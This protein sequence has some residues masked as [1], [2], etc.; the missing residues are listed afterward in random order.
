MQL[1]FSHG[2]KGGVGKSTTAMALIEHCLQAGLQPFLIEGDTGIPDVAA[3]Y[4]GVI[5]GAQIPL[6]RPDLVDEAVGE[7]FE[8]LESSLDYLEGRPVI[9][10]LPAG[11]ASTVDRSAPLIHEVAQTAGWSITTIYLIGAGVE[12]ATAAEESLNSGLAGKSDKKIAVRNLAFG[13]PSRWPWTRGGHHERWEA[14]GG[15]VLDLEEL[16]ARVVNQITG[17]G[18]LGSMVTGEQGGLYLFDRSILQ[19]W[20]KSFSP[21]AE[22]AG[23]L[24][25]AHEVEV[26]EVASNE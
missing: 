18:P 16:A 25:P 4:R 22:A 5:E 14:A 9:V 7:L 21:I 2:E 10:N 8:L 19:R 3:R 13:D 12:S 17:G 20:L 24:S 26:P 15:K 1:I 11:A 23:L 6:S